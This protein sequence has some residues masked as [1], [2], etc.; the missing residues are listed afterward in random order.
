MVA[1]EYDFEDTAWEVVSATNYSEEE[2]KLVY[3]PR[4]W[5]FT[6]DTD[7]KQAAD[8][9][10]EQR[11]PRKLPRE[12]FTTAMDSDTVIQAM[13]GLEAAISRQTRSNGAH[14]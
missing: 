11:L 3:P 10:A 14:S 13:Q 6:N 7:K 9:K 12:T 8:D 5:F 4:Y 1:C 2:M